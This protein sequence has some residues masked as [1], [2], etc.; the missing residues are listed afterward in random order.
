MLQ[1][2]TAYST[3]AKTHCANLLMPCRNYYLL[4]VFFGI[5][6]LYSSLIVHRQQT[7]QKGQ[8]SIKA[9]E[10]PVNGLGY[11]VVTLFHINL[12]VCLAY[13]HLPVTYQQALHLY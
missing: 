9:A 8:K 4:I 6:T 3:A 13:L 5:A 10:K 12:T 1:Q 11:F 2:Y 7:E